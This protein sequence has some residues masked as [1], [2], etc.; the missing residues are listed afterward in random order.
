MISHKSVNWEA[1]RLEY[2]QGVKSVREVARDHGISHTAIQ[3]RAKKEGWQLD[4]SDPIRA[5]A[6]Q[7]RLEDMVT[8]SVA[9]ESEPASVAALVTEQQVAGQG[10]VKQEVRVATEAAIAR[11]QSPN[12]GQG[13]LLQVSKLPNGLTVGRDASGRIIWCML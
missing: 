9:T 12:A 1:I 6:E 7:K 2:R 3:K 4:L 8:K 5:R 10:I 13:G 11:A